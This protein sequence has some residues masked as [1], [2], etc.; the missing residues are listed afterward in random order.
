MGGNC[1][2]RRPLHLG[3]AGPGPVPTEG[4]PAGLLRGQLH[5]Q[6]EEA[7]KAGATPH[8]CQALSPRT[9]ARSSGGHASPQHSE[10]STQHPPTRA[11]FPGPAWVRLMPLG[12]SGRSGWAAQGCR[13]GDP[14]GRCT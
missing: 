13:R 2:L 9:P 10:D 3:P 4:A 14:K 11:R 5:A 6:G 1:G 8:P 7:G 12:F